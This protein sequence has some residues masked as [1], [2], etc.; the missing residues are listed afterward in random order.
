MPPEPLLVRTVGGPHPG[1]KLTDIDQSG[2]P[3]PGLL[4]DVGGKY[5]KVAESNLPPQEEGSHLMRGAM[6]RWRN[7]DEI[8]ED[9]RDA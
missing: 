9:G 5:V 3:L 8:R 6:Y 2:W 4:P 7:D 1:Q